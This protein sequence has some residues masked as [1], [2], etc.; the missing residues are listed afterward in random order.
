MVKLITAKEIR[1]TLFS[2]ATGILE[3]AHR[4]VTALVVR[5]EL[6]TECLE[7]G[8]GRPSLDWLE[9][10][11]RDQIHPKLI[12]ART[13]A[14]KLLAKLPLSEQENAI[15]NG[16]EVLDDDEQ[17]VRLIPVDDLTK[18]QA[19]LA[20]GNSIAKQRTLLRKLKEKLKVSPGVDYKVY[21]DHII[22]AKPMHITR[23]LLLQWL[24]E[25]N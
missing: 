17:T 25:M 8:L 24:Q 4:Y 19:K 10:V 21:R 9:R 11:G 20:I 14:E 7:L 6:R 23:Q 5:P 12:F 2:H 15:A 13:P 3:L 18:E 22:T 1:E 16:V